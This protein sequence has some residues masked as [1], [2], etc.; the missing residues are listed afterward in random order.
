MFFGAESV[1]EDTLK[2][3]NKK[4]TVDHIRAAIPRT[5]EFNIRPVI[6]FVIGFPGETEESINDSL[7]LYDEIMKM[8]PAAHVSGLLLYTPYPGADL[9]DRAEADGFVPPSDLEGWGRWDFNYDTK[10][11]WLGEKMIERLRTIGLLARYRFMKKEFFYRTRSRPLLQVIF[12]L[13]D[14]PLNLSFHLRWKIRSFIHAYE[15]RIWVYAVRKV[16]GYF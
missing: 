12:R 6:S 7:L 10:H 15:W 9:Y 16:F 13:L 8:N 4:I 1:N 14:L 2:M 5:K 3:V 11:P